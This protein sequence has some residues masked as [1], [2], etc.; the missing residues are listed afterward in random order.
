MQVFRFAI[1]AFNLKGD[2]SAQKK[3]ETT[4]AQPAADQSREEGAV[5]LL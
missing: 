2:R 5:K 4:A 1:K 3:E